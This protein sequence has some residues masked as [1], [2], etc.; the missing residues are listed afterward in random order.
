MSDA[1]A[2]A[3]FAARLEQDGAAL[4]M[5]WSKGQTKGQVTRLKLLNRQMYGPAG[6]DPLRRPALVAT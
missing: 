1:R 2:V 5:P 6:F 3:T 4:T